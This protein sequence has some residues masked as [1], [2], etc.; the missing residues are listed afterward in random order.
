MEPEPQP[1]I[2]EP[3][4]APRNLRPAAGYTLTEEIILQDRRI[5][6]NWDRV[7]G[8]TGYTF[9]LYQ[10]ERGINREILRQTALRTPSYT[11]TDLT[12]LDAGEFVWRVEAESG[13][14]EQGTEAATNRFRVSLGEIRAPESRDSGVLFGRE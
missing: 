8:A 10:V 3:L 11:L 6:F 2:P 7:S 1:A 12:L 9:I 14:A 4:P 13:N 5:V